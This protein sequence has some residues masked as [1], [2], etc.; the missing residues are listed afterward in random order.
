M[1]VDGAVAVGSDEPDELADD[2][3][4]AVDV[5]EA[6]GPLVSPGLQPLDEAFAV[7][8]LQVDVAERLSEVGRVAERLL[9]RGF[10]F[11]LGWTKSSPKRS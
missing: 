5:E 1:S 11:P 8:V 6:T 7:E 9:R 3:I 4:D 10:R 2:E